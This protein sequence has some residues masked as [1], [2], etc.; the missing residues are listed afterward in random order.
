M[1]IVRRTC[2]QVL[3]IIVVVLGA[4]PT[5]AQDTDLVRHFEYDRKAPTGLKQL[6]A[7]RRRFATIYDI[8]YDSPKGG[9][10]PAYLVVP[11]GRGPFPAIIWAHWCWTNSSMKNRKQFLDEAVL[12]ARSGVVSL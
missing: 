10:V 11:R 2:L 5:F 9:V 4:I 12:L 6:R 7:E 8:I 1:R 3:P